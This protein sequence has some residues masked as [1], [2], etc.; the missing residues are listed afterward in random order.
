MNWGEALM[1]GLSQAANTTGNLLQQHMQEEQHQ[2]LLQQQAQADRQKMFTEAALKAPTMRTLTDTD[3]NDANQTLVQQQ[4]FQP[5]TQDGVPGT[6]V[7][8][9]VHVLPKSM[10]I[11]QN[12]NMGNGQVGTIGIM[13]DGSQVQL[14][15]GLNPK[16]NP[17]QGLH[18]S[19]FMADNPDGT[20][21]WNSTVNGRPIGTAPAGV[22]PPNAANAAPYV[23]AHNPS[24][25]PNAPAQVAFDKRSGTYIPLN[26]AQAPNFAPSMDLG[27]NPLGQGNQ[28]PMSQF[29]AIESSGPGVPSAPMNSGGAGSMESLPAVPSIGSSGQGG[30][31]SAAPGQYREGTVLHGPGGRMYVV[32]GGVPVPM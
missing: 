13:D 17:A 32:H 15:A 7:T 29:D 11:V 8:D 21:T 28:R 10:K 14:G 26:Q 4:H 23:L 22:I 31:S 9:A 2:Q 5:P 18:Y 6:W 30:A 16:F 20:R 12:A 1:A 27:I 19:G 25:D 3:P 24:D